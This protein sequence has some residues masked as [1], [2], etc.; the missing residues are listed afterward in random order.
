MTLDAVIILR[1]KCVLRL[2]RSTKSPA[3]RRAS[4][5]PQTS[6]TRLDYRGLYKEKTLQLCQQQYL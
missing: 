2:K 1:D 4:P 6:S 5:A 3:E